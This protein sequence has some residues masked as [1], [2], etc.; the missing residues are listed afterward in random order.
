[1][2]CWLLGKQQEYHQEQALRWE[3][4]ESDG[5][6]PS[7]CILFRYFEKRFKVNKAVSHDLLILD[8]AEES[9]FFLI[10]LFFNLV[11][12]LGETG[13]EADESICIF[14]PFCRELTACQ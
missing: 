3:R 11:T 6:M 1:M 12:S 13:N 9:S 7:L 10:R 14:T 5:E 4:K 2:K 8:R